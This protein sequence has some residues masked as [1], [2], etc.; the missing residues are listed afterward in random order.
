MRRRN[1]TKTFTPPNQGTLVSKLHHRLMALRSQ[2]SRRIRISLLIIVSSLAFNACSPNATPPTNKTAASPAQTKLLSPAQRNLWYGEFSRIGEELA[3]ALHRDAN[4]LHRSIET[5]LQHPNQANRLQ[6][7]R[8]WRSTYDKFQAMEPM[9]KY[10]KH[11]APPNQLQ[12]LEIMDQWPIIPGYIDSVSNYPYSGIVNDVTVTLDL[13]TVI[14]QHSL[15]D[16]DEASVGLHVLEFFL[17]GESQEQL[18]PLAQF[19]TQTAWPTPQPEQAISNHPNNRR[20]QYLKLLSKQIQS[21][22]YQMN[23]LWALPRNSKDAEKA[24]DSLYTALG[25]I[26]KDLLQPIAPENQHTTYSDTAHHPMAQRIQ[27]LLY[28][29]SESA[30][31]VG[32]GSTSESSKTPKLNAS[33]TQAENTHHASTRPSHNTQKTPPFSQHLST[34][35]HQINTIVNNSDFNYSDKNWLDRLDFALAQLE[36]TLFNAIAS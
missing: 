16:D 30:T 34:K 10:L 27:T 28:V 19:Q 13:N 8:H 33:L 20:R 25:N 14:A 11:I 15:T 31:P 3:L 17:W 1:T 9:V 26:R 23:T 7:Q 6:A 35:I 21:T 2:S 29:L 18:R 22:C 5:F 36:A 4:Q 32:A 12:Q 24:L